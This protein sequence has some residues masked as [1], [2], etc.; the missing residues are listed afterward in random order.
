MLKHKS[1][2]INEFFGDMPQTITN[3][4]SKIYFR[5]TGHLINSEKQHCNIRFNM[6]KV[7]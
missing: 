1:F 2:E 5:Q 3:T 4:V 6:C 7:G